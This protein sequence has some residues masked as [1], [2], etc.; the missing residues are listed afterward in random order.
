MKNSQLFKNTVVDTFDAGMMLRGGAVKAFQNAQVS[1]DTASVYFHDGKYILTSAHIPEEYGGV[2]PIQ[3]LL[4]KSE[5][6]KIY[7]SG[8]RV[9]PVE[10]FR[11]NGKWKLRIATVEK[12][13]RPDK[14][15]KEKEKEHRKQ[16]NERD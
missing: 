16:I 8:K 4:N 13:S 10:A 15:Q 11:R 9:L 7:K 14:R 3:L 1:L 6:N 5:I 12:L 2:Q